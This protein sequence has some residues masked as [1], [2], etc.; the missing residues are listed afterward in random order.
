LQHNDAWYKVDLQKGIDLALP[1]Q[2]GEESSKCFYAP[3]L[4]VWPV[5]EGSF[6]GSTN[7]GG[8]VNFKNVKLNPHGNGTHTEC[9]GHISKDSIN[10][11][12]C[13]S[14][15]HFFAE[16]ISIYPTLL[17]NGDKVITKAQLEAAMGGYNTPALIIRTQPNGPDKRRRQYSGTNPPYL[18]PQAAAWLA[19]QGIEHLL[20]DLP[21]ID[22]EED[23]GAMAAHKAFWRYGFAVPRTEAT[24]TELI[25]VPPLVK[26]GLYLLNLMVTSLEL[27]ASPSRPVL[28]QLDLQ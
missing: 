13:L 20:L 9:I 17:E 25:Y 10:L 23:G 3:L 11:P 27:D 8:E 15:Y 12:S 24:I 14:H 19:D 2:A 18:E 22:R 4:E 5:I 28:Y 16:L 21:S 6:I 1:L 26:D 7:E